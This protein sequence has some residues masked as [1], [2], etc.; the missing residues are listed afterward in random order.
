MFQW[1]WDAL[2]K[3][4]L[5]HRRWLKSRSFFSLD[6]TKFHW[7]IQSEKELLKKHKNY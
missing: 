6:A 4:K 2:M 7:E 5:I 3:V 1:L